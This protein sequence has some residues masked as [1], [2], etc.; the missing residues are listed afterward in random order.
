MLPRLGDARGVSCLRCWDVSR[1]SFMPFTDWT[2]SFCLFYA[3]HTDIS[4]TED[5]CAR[6]A[7]NGWHVQHVVNGNTDING[8]RDAIARAKAVTDK[9]SLI[10]VWSKPPGEISLIG[11]SPDNVASPQLDAS[12]CCPALLSEK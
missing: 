10:K 8:I 6:Y 5:V 12:A 1:V 11:S 2:A 7:A 3:G 4:F 9:P